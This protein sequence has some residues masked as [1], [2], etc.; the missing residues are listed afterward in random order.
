MLHLK[1]LVA[2]VTGGSSGIGFAITKA[3]LSEGMTVVTTAGD[4]KKLK[5][6]ATRLKNETSG[7]MVIAIQTDVSKS[8]EVEALVKQVMDAYAHIDLLVNNAGIG[9][10][11]RSWNAVRPAYAGLD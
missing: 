2:I 3:L 6:A 10:W 4:E 1:D 5:Q 11:G 7:G 9:R 8:V